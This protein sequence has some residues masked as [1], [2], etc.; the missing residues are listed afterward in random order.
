MQPTL[1]TKMLLEKIEVYSDRI[2]HTTGFFHKQ[3]TIML[4][5]IASIDTGMETV[6]K[7]IIETSGGQKYTLLMWPKDKAALLD[8][9]HKARRKG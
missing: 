3:K 7:I 4:D 9:I 5:Q 2:V 6:G 8:A 1:A